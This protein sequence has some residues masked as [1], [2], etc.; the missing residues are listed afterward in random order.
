MSSAAL[1]SFCISSCL[2]A[3]LPKTAS[4]VGGHSDFAE[5]DVSMGQQA[6]GLHFNSNHSVHCITS[7]YWGLFFSFSNVR[8]SAM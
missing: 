4:G 3:V 1:T 6:R 5:F 2:A 7:T 8:I